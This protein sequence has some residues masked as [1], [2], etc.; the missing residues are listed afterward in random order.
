MS[1]ACHM[2][3]SR[4]ARVHYTEIVNN[5]MVSLDLCDECAEEKGVDLQKSEGH[6][7]GDLVAGLIDTSVASETDRIGKVS[8]A[9]CGYDYSDFKKI[10]RFGCPDCYEAFEAQLVPILR[11][12]HG[13][14][15]HDGTAPPKLAAPATATKKVGVLRGE[16]ERAISDEDYE[17]A[18]GLRD[19]I[20]TLEDPSGEGDDV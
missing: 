7:L 18:A 17:R 4:P 6:G 9:S 12:V 19:E 11:H 8:C 16:L 1:V 2:C 3:K 14:T 13:T 20:R 10:G 5:N 15:S